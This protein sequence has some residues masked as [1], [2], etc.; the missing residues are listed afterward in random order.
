MKINWRTLLAISKAFTI[1]FAIVFAMS[2]IYTNSES[3]YDPLWDTAYDLMW[4]GLG[5]TLLFAILWIISKIKVE[6]IIMEEDRIKWE[7]QRKIKEEKKKQ[8]YEEITDI[9][10]YGEKPMFA[11]SPSQ[12]EET[13]G[14]IYYV[15]LKYRNNDST[16]WV[17]TINNSAGFKEDFIAKRKGNTLVGLNGNK[18]AIMKKGQLTI[19]NEIFYFSSENESVK[20][21]SRLMKELL[22][23]KKI[24]TVRLEHLEAASEDVID[25]LPKFHFSFTEKGLK[26]DEIN[27]PQK[28][29]EDFFEKNNGGEHVFQNK[30]FY[31]DYCKNNGLYDFNVFEERDF[32]E[33]M[34][35]MQMRAIKSGYSCNTDFQ[36]S[37]WQVSIR[38]G[39]E[40]L[41]KSF[42]SYVDKKT[43][44]VVPIAFAGNTIYFQHKHYSPKNNETMLFHNLAIVSME[45]ERMDNNPSYFISKT[46]D[47]RILIN[48]DGETF[49]GLKK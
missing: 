13:G 18:I 27:Y 40:L 9:W 33:Y 47:G 24:E 10:E 31:M 14:T 29:L 21:V 49:V 48:I 4:V 19:D 46:D 37:E 25:A 16:P 3:V 2:L 42:K 32:Y 8:Q 15:K 28:H 34:H 23:G 17:I 11:V 41:F 26:C 1:M 30:V 39:V 44:D 36:L 12:S 20:T 35:A 22:N 7:E 38:H 45:E 43:L 5:G 6:D